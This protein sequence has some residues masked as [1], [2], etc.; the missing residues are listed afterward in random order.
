MATPM[1]PQSVSKGEETP[2]SDP[3]QPNPPKANPTPTAPNRSNPSISTPRACTLSR[4]RGSVSDE[5]PKQA[6]TPILHNPD[7]SNPVL[8]K[9][10]QSTPYRT[11]SSRV[12]IRPLSWDAGLVAQA[13]LRR[14]LPCP[15]QTSTIRATSIQSWPIRANPSP[16]NLPS[17]CRG[18]GAEYARKR[19][20]ATVRCTEPSPKPNQTNYDR[21][22]T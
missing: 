18:G 17:P 20:K 11:N 1:I 13:K 5:K 21:T 3:Q 16:I 8:L 4:W 10:T 19:R 7:H 6:S 22:H 15:K 9:T 2:H 12:S 14:I